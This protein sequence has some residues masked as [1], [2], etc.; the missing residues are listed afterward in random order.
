MN[1]VVK[2]LSD[3]SEVI[4]YNLFFTTVCNFQCR[5]RKH[6]RHVITFF[7]RVANRSFELSNFNSSMAILTGLSFGPVTRLKKTWN[8][9]SLSELT[10]LQVKLFFTNFLYSEIHYLTISITTKKRCHLS[11][12][13]I[14][15]MVILS[16]TVWKLSPR[17]KLSGCRI[18]NKMLKCLEVSNRLWLG[19]LKNQIPK[20]QPIFAN[21]NF[22]IL[23]RKF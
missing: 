6:A 19:T 14:W 12:F 1:D 15:R 3:M 11:T 20:F 2:T 13:S 7:A 21:P 10:K 16:D 5:K 8:K 4:L 18:I 23:Q 17:K 9:L 22:G